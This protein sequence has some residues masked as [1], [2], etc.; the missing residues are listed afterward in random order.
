MAAPR[1]PAIRLHDILDAIAGVR[2][3]RGSLSLEQFRSDWIRRR[4]IERGIEIISEATRHLPD[5]LKKTEPQ[6]PWPQ[7][8]G[9]GNILRHGYDQIE[10]AVIFE[11]ASDQLD[12][13]DAAVRR[14]LVRLGDR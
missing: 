2:L 1:D 9:V 3:A 4:A 10:D 11:I 8:A 5:E 14:M 6:L 7:I 13:L 12:D